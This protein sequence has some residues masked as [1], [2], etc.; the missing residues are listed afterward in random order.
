M[1]IPREWR[2]GDPV[3]AT[4]IEILDAK[5][6]ILRFGGRENEPDSQLMRVSNETHQGLK[7]GDEIQMR[8]E[9]ISPLRFRY[10]EKVEEQRR[11]G[12]LDVSI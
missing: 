10:V 4:V 8:V 7:I 5:Y 11:R 2:R 9:Q 1:N 3:T 12:R 6:L